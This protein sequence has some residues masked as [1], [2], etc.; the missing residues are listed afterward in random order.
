MTD[1]LMLWVSLLIYAAVCL[2][3]AGGAV[4]LGAWLDRTFSSPLMTVVYVV[5]MVTGVLAAVVSITG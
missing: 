1:F 3:V 5:V 4:L 2:G